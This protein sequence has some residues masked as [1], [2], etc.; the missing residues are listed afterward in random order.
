MRLMMKGEGLRDLS[1]FVALVK[2]RYHVTF[3]NVIF[4][5]LIFAPRLTAELFFRLAFSTSVSTSC[6]TGASMR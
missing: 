4:G 2:L 3:L 6:S 1:S 5:A